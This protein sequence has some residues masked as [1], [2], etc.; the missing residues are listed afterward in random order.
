MK[1]EIDTVGIF[2]KLIWLV[3]AASL[4]FAAKKVNDMSNNI[5]DLNYKVGTAIM[6][7]ADKSEVIK[8]HSTILL[9]HEK[10]IIRL[11]RQ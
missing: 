1:V 8:D 11:E 5:A 4:T 9:D 2:N 10:R 3:I 7:Q 6:W